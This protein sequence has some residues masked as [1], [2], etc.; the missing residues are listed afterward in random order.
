MV[1]TKVIYHL[2]YQAGKT[3]KKTV[4]LMSFDPGGVVF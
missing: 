2:T 3:G 1:L 4:M